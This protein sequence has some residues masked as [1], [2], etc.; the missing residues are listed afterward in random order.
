MKRI[1][2]IHVH[3]SDLSLEK[4]QACLDEIA[5]LGVSHVALQSITYHSIAYNLSLL[6][7][8]HHYRKMDLS[9]FGM[10]H[11]EDFYQEIP[12]EVQAKALLDMGCDGI[13]FMY[14]P[15]TRRRLAHG[16]CDER[17]EKMFAYLEEYEIPMLI[18][19]NDPESYW[20]KREL[21]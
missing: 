17:Y 9:V 5:G 18:H 20:V 1:A 13:K 16:I 6:Y 19:V 10:I 7:W 12:Y 21:T 8:K 3:M 4:C 11:N 15:D 2:D 14:S